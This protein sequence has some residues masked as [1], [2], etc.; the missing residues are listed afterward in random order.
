MNEPKLS[1]FSGLFECRVDGKRRTDDD[2]MLYSF[3]IE[4]GTESR[5]SIDSRLSALYLR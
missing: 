2:Q 5:E 1:G 3:E 4:P